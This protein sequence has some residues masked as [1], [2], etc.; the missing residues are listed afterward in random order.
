ML[1][2]LTGMRR[3]EL[4]GL[5]WSDVDLQTLVLEVPDPWWSCPAAG[6]VTLGGGVNALCVDTFEIGGH[7]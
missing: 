2:A 1:A 5:R 3:G 4:C 6:A 7:A